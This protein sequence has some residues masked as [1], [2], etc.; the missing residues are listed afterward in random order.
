MLVHNS[1]LYILFN[2]DMYYRTLPLFLELPVPSQK[3]WVC[4]AWL[5]NDCMQSNWKAHYIELMLLLLNEYRLWNEFET[6]ITICRKHHRYLTV[7]SPPLIISR[8]SSHMKSVVS[9]L[10]RTWS[11]FSNFPN[12]TAH[13]TSSLEND[14]SNVSLLQ[15]MSRGHVCKFGLLLFLVFVCFALAVCK[16]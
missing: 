11:V 2:S 16:H 4:W 14:L 10:F 12:K 15:P 8:G 13:V 1:D 6:K 3:N 9:G 5:Y 7:W